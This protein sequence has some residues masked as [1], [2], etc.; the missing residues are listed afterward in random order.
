MRLTASDDPQEAAIVLASDEVVA[1]RRALEV[2]LDGNH[3]WPVEFETR[4]GVT[5]AEATEVLDQV[6]GLSTDGEATLPVTATS[7]ALLADSLNEVVNGIGLHKID[8]S[9][10]PPELLAELHASLRNSAVAT[11]SGR[12]RGEH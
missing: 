12:G 3:I 7:L 9:I 10:G 2:I 4:L 6:A 1:L 5:V 11:R 8:G